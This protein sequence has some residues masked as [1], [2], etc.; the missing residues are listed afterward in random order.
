[1]DIIQSFIKLADEKDI[2]GML[3]TAWD[4][5][6]PHMETYWRGLIASG[7]FSWNPA[8]RSLEEYEEAYLQREFGPE[9]MNAG[10]LY[11][12]MFQAVSFWN[13]AL[14]T[15]GNRVR[16][17]EPLDLPDLDDPGEWS[18][19][20]E[21]RLKTAAI[22]AQKYLRLKE[23]LEELRHK[24]RRNRYHIELLSAINDFQVTSALLLLALKECDLPDR[25]KRAQGMERVQNVLNEFDI[26][27]NRL[28]DIYG[29]TRFLAYPEE[30][31]RDRYFHMASRTE[32]LTWMIEVDKKFHKKIRDWLD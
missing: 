8:G 29:K 13:R 5:S 30:Y 31:V 25:T 2:D 28:K 20:H 1:V 6:S 23:Q 11:S 21:D 19:K 10:Q 27:W 3:C 32:D 12:E 7:E 26:A 24:A 17:Q 16:Y 22:E 14:C 15:K 18:L 4:D 9:C